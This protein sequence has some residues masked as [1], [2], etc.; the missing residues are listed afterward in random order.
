MQ[1]ALADLS[2]TN[3]DMKDSL[4]HLGFTIGNITSQQ[5]NLFSQVQ[6]LTTTLAG[7]FSFYEHLAHT[8]QQST[9]LASEY[10][11]LILQTILT[12]NSLQQAQSLVSTA[13]T[14]TDLSQVDTR[15]VYTCRVL[16]HGLHESLSRAKTEFV[17]FCK[18]ILSSSPCQNSPKNMNKDID[19]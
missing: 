7:T 16:P 18:D 4:S 2:K 19:I 13:V 14:G 11:A 1:K 12:L 6:Y 10:S 17:F 15:T 5:H 9:M 8:N 3:F